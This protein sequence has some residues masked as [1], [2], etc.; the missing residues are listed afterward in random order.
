MKSLQNEIQVLSRIKGSFIAQAYYSFMKDNSLFIM[1]EY[2][3][4][5]DLRDLL[6]EWGCMTFEEA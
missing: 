3:E 6:E 1:M 4:G 2:L 5:G